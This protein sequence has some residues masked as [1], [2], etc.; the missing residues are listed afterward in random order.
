MQIG[1]ILVDRIHQAHPK[2]IKDAYWDVIAP[3]SLPFTVASQEYI[4]EYPEFSTKDVKV[5]H[6]D[7]DVVIPEY[8]TQVTT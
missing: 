4:S 6:L 1:Y 2:L 8:I 3:S 5:K 7:Q